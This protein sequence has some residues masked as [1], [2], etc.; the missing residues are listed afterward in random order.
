MEVECC[1]L[2]VGSF[3][4]NIVS[5]AYGSFLF[6]LLVCTYIEPGHFLRSLK[7]YDFMH[8]VG[9]EMIEYHF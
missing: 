7:I 9:A 6:T 5:S 3:F 1:W 8:L 4:S 2:K